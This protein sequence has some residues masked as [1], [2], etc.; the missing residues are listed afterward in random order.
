MAR[1]KGFMVLF[2]FII[3]STFQGANDGN[4]RVE[5]AVGTA[6]VGGP[7]SG[8]VLLRQR[9]RAGGGNQFVRTRAG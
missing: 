6:L 9:H 2:C 5:N 4:R 8:L 7:V 1:S 3:S